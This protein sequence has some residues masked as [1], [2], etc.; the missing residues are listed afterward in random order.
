M[1]REIK[2]RAWDK[3]DKKIFTMD[4]VSNSLG[5]YFQYTARTYLEGEEFIPRFVQMQYTG[6]KESR[7]L[8]GEYPKKEIYEGDII[9]KDGWEESYV[10]EFE[11]GRYVARKIREP[12]GDVFT[13][14]DEDLDCF[15]YPVVVGNRFDNPE[16]L[17]VEAK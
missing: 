10:V 11:E 17:K 16:L 5:L 3:Q 7:N 1:G 13:R 2:F 12:K 15:L 14:Y 8:I 4:D 6:L 9:E